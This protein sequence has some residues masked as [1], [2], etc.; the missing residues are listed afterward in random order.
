MGT[1]GLVVSQ[2]SPFY[3]GLPKDLSLHMAKLASQ[4][5]KT[6]LQRTSVRSGPVLRPRLSWL[7]LMLGEDLKSMEAVKRVTMHG[8]C[9]QS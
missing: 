4:M 2:L 9:G 6:W 3:V 5:V 7:E 1:F 8:G